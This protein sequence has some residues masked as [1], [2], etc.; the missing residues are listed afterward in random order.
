MST[1]SANKTAATS[2]TLPYL[3]NVLV[4]QGIIDSGARDLLLRSEESE[5]RAL[6]RLRSAGRDR[7]QAEVTPVELLVFMAER[8]GLGLADLSD[9][10]VSQALAA[11]LGL[12]FRRIDTLELDIEFISSIISQPFARKHLMIP[13]RARGSE[14]EV[15]LADPFDRE[16]QDT[17]RRTSGYEVRPVLVTRRD[18]LRVVREFYG[19]RRSVIKAEQHLAPSFDLGNLEQYVRMK[20]EADIESSDQHIVDAVE[21]LL[22]HA[23]DLRASDIHLEPKR[24]FSRVRVRIDGVMH[25]VQQVPKIVHSAMVSRIKTLARMNIAEKRRPQDGRIKTEREGREVELRVSTLPVAFGEKVV[26]R[27][28]NPEITAQKLDG[29]GFFPHDQ[30]VFEALLAEPHGILLVTGP[31]G[32]GKT[33]TL[34]SALRI[35]ADGETNIVTIEDPIEMVTEEFNQTAVQPAIGL[36]FAA[37]LRTILRQDPDI[38]MVGEIRDLETAENAVQAAL[39]GHLVLSTLHTNDAAASITRLFDLGVEPFQIA[40]TLLGVMAQRLVRRVCPHCARERHLKP[41]EAE[42]LGLRVPDGKALP[43]RQGA[44][45][46]R[47]RGTGF[48]GQSGIF[49]V[50]AMD[51]TLRRLV[52]DRADGRT[53]KEAARRRGMTTLRECAVRKMAQGITTF[54]EVLRVTG[55]R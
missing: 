24:D 31:T 48:L 53:L 30:E 16:G 6:Q 13:L 44:G 36:D 26:I 15:A 9:E 8:L 49:E 45:C 39:T 43:V 11:H 50:M 34:Y 3:A 42:L 38:V 17:I 27:I 1:H 5:R 14:L 41:E 28:F 19:F 7:G 32:S 55:E 46:L 22:L 10:R 21:Y 33:T 51:E 35:L 37:V 47:C 52:H 20:K 18:L 40:D 29:L 12:P 2:L 25:A 54:E 4:V 23:F